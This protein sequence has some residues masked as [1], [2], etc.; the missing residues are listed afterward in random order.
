MDDCVVFESHRRKKATSG[1]RVKRVNAVM[2]KNIPSRIPEGIHRNK[3]K[4]DGRII[5]LGFHRS[6]SSKD[7][8]QLIT[9]AF[10]DVCQ[11]KKLQFLQANRD[12]TFQVH[13]D[14]D[15][16]GSGILTLAGSGSLYMLPIEENEGDH[17]NQ[18][19]TSAS[20]SAPDGGRRK[21]LL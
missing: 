18:P 13:Q 15:P 19:C 16:D 3:L 11:V 8:L 5:E 14:Q 1:K 2:L 17:D 9:D 20:I 7:T 12:N 21:V 10:S 4:E 6:M